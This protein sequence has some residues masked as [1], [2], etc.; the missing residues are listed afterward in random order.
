MPI[1][2]NSLTQAVRKFM[3]TLPRQIGLRGLRHSHASHMLAANVHP[4]VVQE[5]I[6]TP[7]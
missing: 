3:L 2:P 7:A 6:G 5:R 4:K 1:K